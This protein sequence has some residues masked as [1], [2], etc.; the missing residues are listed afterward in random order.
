MALLASM[1]WDALF[2]D[3][4]DQEILGV[5]PVRPRTLAAAR[6]RAAVTLGAIFAAAIN[7]PTALLYSAVSAVHPLLGSFPRV[8]FAHVVSTTAACAS[9]SPTRW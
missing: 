2:P 8:L 9:G 4:T 1:T 6:L 7:L 5:L 3:R